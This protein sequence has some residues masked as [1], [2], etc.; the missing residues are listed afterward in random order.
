[1]N[2]VAVSAKSLE[3][4][5]VIQV[6][7]NAKGKFSILGLG[8]GMWE[9]STKMKGYLPF[10]TQRFV[11]Q[12]VRNEPIDFKL[13]ESPEATIT[14]EKVMKRVEN[15]NKLYD[16][17]NYQDSIVELE[18][19]LKEF[20]DLFFLNLNI[21]NAY[22]KLNNG[23]KAMEYYEKVIKG[24]QKS[25]GLFVVDLLKR[26]YIPMGE[27]YAKKNNFEKAIEYYEKAVKLNIKDDKV[28][29]NL[30]SIYFSR[31]LTQKAVD[32]FKKAIEINPEWGK[33]YVKLGYAYLN[34]GQ[35]NEAIEI[36]ERYMQKFPDAKDFNQISSL[37]L[38]LRKSVQ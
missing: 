20:P 1:M 16:N 17:E 19:I 9:I 26:S 14:D 33:P 6:K 11:R 15:A 36:L 25:E 27:F 2:G 22:K 10:T 7:T 18:G 23:E 21:A 31:N 35:I 8:T 4:A 34:A 37:V 38:Q 30:G 3:H 29:Y 24:A 28:F 13:V 32:V 5:R 12:L